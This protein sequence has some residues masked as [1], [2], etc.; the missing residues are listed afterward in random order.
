MG[1]FRDLME[2]RLQ[3][4]G[5]SPSTCDAYLRQVGHLVRYCRRPPD[6]IC[7]DDINRYQYHLI[8]EKKVSYATLNQAVC[9]I[10]FF[11]SFCLKVDWK[12]EEIP[13]HKTPRRLPQIL[14]VAEICALFEA[15][16]NLKHLSILM[17][18]YSGGLRVSEIVHLKISDIDSRRMVIRVDQGKGRKDRYVMLSEKLLATLREY[19]K[20][21][22]PKY[23]LFPG[24]NGKPLNPR[25]V[26]RALRTIKGRA[27]IS[28]EVTVHS[29]RHAFA[30]HLLE[31]GT[32]IRIIQRLLGH[33]S[34]KATQLY[35]Q[36]ANDYLTA[37]KSPLDR[38]TG[39]GQ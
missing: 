2:Q 13:Y 38:A 36:V 6:Q 14:N 17:I 1:K 10:R 7:V 28:K 11:Y 27:G 5:Y 9:A 24:R 21:Y 22:K 19:Y 33:R 31:G 23:W 20:L 29:L 32:N 39:G 16:S 26:H 35:T 12:I 25:S 3:I 34:L 4:R 37:T 15:T 30:T 18:G 8:S